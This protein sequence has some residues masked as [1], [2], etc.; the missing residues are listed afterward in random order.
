[1]M[2]ANG[3]NTDKRFRKETHAPE[4]IIVALLHHRAQ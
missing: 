4:H 2:D 3:G 1:M